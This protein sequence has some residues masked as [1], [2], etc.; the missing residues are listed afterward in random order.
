MKKTNNLH[1]IY[2][3]VHHGKFDNVLLF[4]FSIIGMTRHLFVS[5]QSLSSCR[6]HWILRRVSKPITAT[7]GQR[8]FIDLFAENILLRRRVKMSRTIEGS[9]C[10]HKCNCV[11]KKFF[12]LSFNIN[13]SAIYL[14]QNRGLKTF[15]EHN[16]I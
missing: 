8:M 16:C 14:C 11:F 15:F 12:S 4:L 10:S 13:I 3:D 1:L 9:L 2:Y 7:A 5:K 6:S